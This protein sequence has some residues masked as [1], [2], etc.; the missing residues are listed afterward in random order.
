MHVMLPIVNLMR[1][2][3]FSPRLDISI[4]EII[5]AGAQDFIQKPFTIAA[6]S[7]KLKRILEGE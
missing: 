4:K 6:L 5:D 3:K 2:I 7:E 1:S